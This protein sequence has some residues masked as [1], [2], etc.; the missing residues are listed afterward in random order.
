M[1][2][3]SR[4][5]FILTNVLHHVLT[6]EV[7]FDPRHYLGVRIQ[8]GVPVLDADLNEMGDLTSKTIEL[9]IR[10]VIG[11]GVASQGTG[12]LISQ[13]ESDND[14]AIQ[15]GVLMTGGWQ[16]INPDIIVYSQQP[17][18]FD[19][20]GTPLGTDLT[21]PAGDR[22]DIVYLDVWESVTESIGDNADPRLVQA[23]IGIETAV[24]RERRWTVRVAEN[25]NAFE[26]LTLDET[27]HKY[28]PLA[29]LFRSNVPRIQQHMIED[30]RRLGLTLAEG[31]KSPM[32]LQRGSEIVDP[33]RFSIML[34]ELRSSLQTWQ[35][36]SLFPVVIGSVE[37]LLIYQNTFN[38]IYTIS[39]T[40]EVNSDTFNLDNNDGL[41]VLRKMTDAQRSMVLALRTISTGVPG[42]MSIYDL[43]D[44][45][46]E[47]DPVRGI[48]GIQPALDNNDLLAA[49]LG[50]EALTTFLGLSTGELPEGNVIATLASV[51]PPSAISEVDG[52]TITYDVTSDLLSPTTAEIFELASVV[53]DVRWAVSLD[54]STLTLAPG[55]TGQVEMT[56]DPADTLTD[57]DSATINLV[58]SAQRRASI[59]SVQAAQ[60][61]T[62]GLAPP[63]ATFFFYS[64]IVSLVGGVLIIPRI[65]IEEEIYEVNFNLVNSTG[66]GPGQ[67]QIFR[68]DY[69]L[70]WPGTLP[71]NVDPNT[72]IPNLP[73]VRE[74]QEVPNANIT[75][76]IPIRAPSLATVTENISFTLQITA[77]LTS[78]NDNVPVADG[79]TTTINLPITVNMT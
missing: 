12:F 15:A 75:A 36:N 22:T 10:D 21:T 51:S 17:R 74:N 30:R 64:G 1:A 11:D 42:D 26:D 20:D 46:L 37:S 58:A 45:Y 38:E 48:S 65:E 3:Y 53:S 62:I 60:T 61:F 27:G 33:A 23:E 16:V 72:W 39:A 5:T 67:G 49:V 79:K 47:G 78:V 18:F 56:V 25:T 76:I 50:Q 40:S 13:I 73:V 69:A 44:A 70:I 43:Y 8:Q 9:L 77:T 29:R 31:I 24:R 63:G 71:A 54:K 41:T 52:F 6:D 28:Y 19:N 2:D 14:F 55:E 7:V 57:G 68:L 59:K 34:S 32:F 66:G 4:D 35:N